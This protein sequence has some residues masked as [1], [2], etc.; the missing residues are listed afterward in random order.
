MATV[1]T[2][3]SP[4]APSTARRSNVRASWADVRLLGCV[5]A[6]DLVY[7]AGL[8]VPYLTRDHD[9]TTVVPAWLGWPAFATVFVL[10]L[11]AVGCGAVAVG[12][13]GAPGGRRR[14]A[15]AVLV[16]AVVGLAAY[17]S[18]TGIAAVRWFLD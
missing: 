15:A 6:V 13:L 8:L 1:T 14:V 5:A 16:L 12:R 3:G 17:V 7:A 10:P 4:A 9:P 18:P 2:G 11:V